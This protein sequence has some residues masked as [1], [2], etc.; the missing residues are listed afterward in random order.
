[1]ECHVETRSHH[2]S[3]RAVTHFSGTLRVPDTL[4][5]TAAGR[6][7]PTLVWFCDSNHQNCAILAIYLTRKI[8]TGLFSIEVLCF[9]AGRDS[10]REPSVMEIPG[11]AWARGKGKG[12]VSE[13]REAG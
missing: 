3:A 1:M 12:H 7:K 5:E 2:F 6:S 13:L 8:R 10:I 4:R 9:S 11:L